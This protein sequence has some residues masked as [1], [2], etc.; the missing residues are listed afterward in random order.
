MPAMRTTGAIGICIAA[1]LASL[2]AGATSGRAQSD[3]DA[4]L[5]AI[6]NHPKVEARLKASKARLVWMALPVEN[7]RA[8]YMLKENHPTHMRRSASIA[9]TGR[10]PRSSSTT[11]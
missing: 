5:A 9:S 7:N 3:A 6:V 8:C 4:A 2:G 11:W 10:P 1:L